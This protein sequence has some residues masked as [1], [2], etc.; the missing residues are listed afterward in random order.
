[1]VSTKKGLFIFGIGALILLAIALSNSAII[2]S[3]DKAYSTLIFSEI[4]NRKFLNKFERNCNTIQNSAVSMLLTEDTNEILC[5]QRE[6]FNSFNTCDKFLLSLEKS[7]FPQKHHDLIVKLRSSY[8]SYKTSCASYTIKILESERKKSS[9]YATT[10]L[11]KRL[12]SLLGTIDKVAFE[13]DSEME[14]GSSS[15][16]KQNALALIFITGAGIVPVAFWGILLLLT[17]LWTS[18]AFRKLRPNQ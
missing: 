1:M 11:Q 14:S 15:I 13:I 16:T 10:V 18:A 3:V 8:L 9:T 5:L 17:L 4:S 6:I 7:D 12:A 2:K